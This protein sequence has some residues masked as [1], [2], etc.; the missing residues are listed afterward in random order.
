MR[1]VLDTLVAL[2][3]VGVLGGITWQQR[4]ERVRAERIEGVRQAISAIESQS[5]YH[6]A[7]GDA[8][9]TVHGYAV[10]IDPAWFSPRPMNLLLETHPRWLDQAAGEERQR[11]HPAG[12]VAE[13]GWAAFW[14]NPGRGLVRAR[15]PMQ[16]SHQATV[17]LYNRVN[18]SSVDIQDVQWSSPPPSASAGKTAATPKAAEARAS[19]P[20]LRDF[21]MGG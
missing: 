6:A 2:M 17:D 18:S 19:D 16:L 8:E 4:A 7:L 13:G 5:L 11:F 9:A 15:V 14:Y 12:I 3:L 1:L 20:V 21:G 10:R